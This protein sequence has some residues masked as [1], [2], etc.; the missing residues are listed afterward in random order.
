MPLLRSLL[1][2]DFRFFGL[3]LLV[4]MSGLSS[5]AQEHSQYDRGTPPQNAAGVS[6][7]GSFSSSDIGAVN[8]ANGGLNLKLPL[9]LVGGRGFS[10]PITLNYS[11]KVWS[12]SRG[13]DD[14][15]SLD[16]GPVT[17]KVVYASYGEADYSID[18]Y[19]RIVPGWTI[20]AQPLLRARII[21]IAPVPNS[22]LSTYTLTKLTLVLPDKGEIELRDDWT[23]GAPIPVPQNSG[24]GYRDG[25][26]GDRWHASDGSG[27]IFV[28]D[29]PNGPVQGYLAGY[30]ITADGTRYRFED[31]LA[32]YQGIG[33]AR[34]HS[35]T[36]RNG[37]QITISY[38]NAD[39]VRYMDQLGRV[40]TVQRGVA[41]P[42]T[43]GVTLDLLI[44]FPGYNNQPR[45]FKVIFGTMSEH[46]RA[47][48][49]PALACGHRKSRL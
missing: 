38:P 28:S 34:C 18:Y 48:V 3:L 47:D 13:E 14:D 42:S 11:S 40:T 37:N 22:C 27:L 20:G 12:A 46:Y 9:G 32:P 1:K 33:L 4:L 15:N 43:P 36:D 26:R 6:S 16:S 31:N 25:F 8:L 10:L 44:T 17:R 49:N 23:N 5:S 39:E 24:C 35:I 19:N 7:L 29:N 21:N 2:V 45:Y 41:D 30:V